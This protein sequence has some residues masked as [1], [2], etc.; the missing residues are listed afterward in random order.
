[1]F[2]SVLIGTVNSHSS[3]PSELAS[4]HSDREGKRGSGQPLLTLQG[5][6]EHIRK[7]EPVS[8]ACFSCSS[9]LEGYGNSWASEMLLSIKLC[10]RISKGVIGTI[11]EAQ[12]L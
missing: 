9:L 1:M 6:H 10:N 2:D 11:E 5:L 12:I 3:V 7:K 4:E 8:A